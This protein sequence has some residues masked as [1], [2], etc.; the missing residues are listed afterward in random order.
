MKL[1][2]FEHCI[3]VEDP[4]KGGALC[5]RRTSSSL[6]LQHIACSPGSDFSKFEGRMAVGPP[7]DVCFILGF[8]KL[9][10][11]KYMLVVTEDERKVSHLLRKAESGFISQLVSFM[12]HCNFYFS[13]THD[14]TR[15]AQ[16]ISNLTEA[17]RCMPQWMQADRRFFWNFRL[18]KDM[19]DVELHDWIVPVMDGC[20]KMDFHTNTIHLHTNQTSGIREEDF[21]CILISRRECSRTGTRFNARGADP[22]GHVANFVETEQLIVYGTIISSF[23]MTRGSVPL[24][25]EQKKG[26]KPK[27]VLVGSKFMSEAFL[28]HMTR[29]VE[30]YKSV[31][32]VSLLDH[33][34]NEQ[35]LSEAYE[36]YFNFFAI[37]DTKFFSFDFHTECK[38]NSLENIQVLLSL[39]MKDL[40]ANQYFL[41]SGSRLVLSQSGVFRVN[42]VDCLDRTNVVQSVFAKH[43]IQKQLSHLGF[44]SGSDSLSALPFF[45]TQF[46]AAWVNNANY[47]SSQYTGT[48]ALKTDYTKAGKIGMRA[49]VSD[50]VTCL[51][52]IVQQYQDDDKQEAID[53]FLGNYTVGQGSMPAVFEAEKIDQFGRA[54]GVGVN[55]TSSTFYEYDNDLKHL[56]EFPL[57]E[58]ID[59]EKEPKNYNR[60][61]V[62]MERAAAATT[63]SFSSPIFREYFLDMIR[64]YRFGLPRDR[65]QIKSNLSM[66]IGSW[67][68]AGQTPKEQHLADW[69]PKTC[70]L[71]A[72]AVQACAYTPPSTF[73]MHDASH[74]TLLLQ[75]HFG[76]E[77]ESIATV[78]VRQTTL[79]ILAKKAILPS[80]HAIETCSVKLQ[81]RGKHT[82]DEADQ[83]N[84]PADKQKNVFGGAVYFDVEETRICLMNYQHE[85]HSL[86]KGDNYLYL[87]KDVNLD[88]DFQ[89][90]FW[91]GSLDSSV[92]NNVNSASSCWADLYPAPSN[93]GSLI[94][95][96]LH[97]SLALSSIGIHPSDLPNSP[98]SLQFMLPIVRQP[99]IPENFGTLSIGLRNLSANLKVSEGAKKPYF[100]I[101]A[102][103]LK[104]P[105]KTSAQSKTLTPVWSEQ[106]EL[107]IFVCD[108]EFLATQ[109]L[110]VELWAKGLHSS[111]DHI[112][113]CG[114]LPLVTVI[115]SRGD[116]VPFEVELLQCGKAVA[117]ARGE[118]SAQN[119][120][121][122]QP[123]PRTPPGQT[124]TNELLLDLDDDVRTKPILIP[125]STPSQAVQSTSPTPSPSASPNL[126]MP[127]SHMDST[128]ARL[129]PRTPSPP[130]SGFSLP[131]RKPAIFHS[132]TGKFSQPTAHPT[133]TLAANV[134][135]VST[136]IDKVPN[137]TDNI[138]QILIDNLPPPPQSLAISPRMQ[139]PTPSPASSPTSTPTPS[140]ITITTTAASETQVLVPPK[141]TAIRT[142]PTKALPRVPSPPSRPPPPPPPSATS[143]TG[144]SSTSPPSLL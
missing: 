61:R 59:I 20:I 39:T 81:P 63:Y 72:I 98:L 65:I 74:W 17:I 135:P 47:L 80:I 41:V 21:K 105:L 127:Q 136:T 125:T 82:T 86:P 49:K 141:P 112:F 89:H 71:Y 119:T 77:F 114:I 50:G 64:C 3:V 115:K 38:G 130:P 45:D 42:C 46:T 109:H 122:G 128:S 32:I 43:M 1:H 100:I 85:E 58:L 104:G 106:F 55:I 10:S 97:S 107:L 56:T 34:G 16:S 116:Y 69:I 87:R 12:E 51:K 26:F 4:K 8:L 27:P 124:S 35:E 57:S 78:T 29:Q 139:D 37:P 117:L 133:P 137:S 144:S 79:T 140:V 138:P 9:L 95:R 28:R 131:W 66:F 48:S 5:V 23:V 113:G 33:N 62:F 2:S 68:L 96:P 52:R 44:I 120:T 7:R 88:V 19:R 22:F 36:R 15:C 126:L 31:Y 60:V 13:F 40:E 134:T 132:I 75:K 73:A 25:W 101:H 70:D 143:H 84:R 91:I 102:P 111:S 103:F 67:N 129:R 142:A 94:Y 83:P 18:C 110:V 93:S 53:L 90:L 14:I 24:L 54:T 11:G 108:R 76:R 118:L 121:S 92:V 30:L 123:N 6:A 99:S